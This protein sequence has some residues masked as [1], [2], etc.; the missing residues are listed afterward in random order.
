MMTIYSPLTWRLKS[1]S[2]Q[3]TDLKS[4]EICTNIRRRI[5]WAN[6]L[7]ITKNLLSL[8]LINK[9]VNNMKHWKG[10]TLKSKRMTANMTYKSREVRLQMN[11]SEKSSIT[12]R[13]TIQSSAMIL[14]VTNHRIKSLN[15]QIWQWKR[16]E[17]FQTKTVWTETINH[18]KC[19]KLNKTVQS[20]V[21]T[22]CYLITSFSIRRM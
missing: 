9:M 22:R 7:Q 14:W 19:T 20:F 16:Q 11:K 4:S 3:D 5:W 8:W 13:M 10:S 6:Q 15:K 17:S 2:E 21:I 18:W 1:Y 12:T